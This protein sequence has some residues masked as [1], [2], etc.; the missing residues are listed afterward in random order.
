MICTKCKNE[1][2]IDEFYDKRKTSSKAGRR[3]TIC[4]WCQLERNRK[5]NALRRREHRDKLT[6]I[7]LGRGC[8]DCGFK[9][10]AQALQFDH[11]EPQEKK[12]V[13]AHCLLYSWETI[14]EEVAKC[15][16]RCSICHTKR[17]SGPKVLAAA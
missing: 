4:K 12:F 14:L 5:L 2:S 17:H 1:R 8:I 7:K 13:I 6:E 15:D 10:Y 9:A 11:R 16:V 3:K